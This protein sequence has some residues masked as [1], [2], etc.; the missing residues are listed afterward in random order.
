MRSLTQQ[1][2]AACESARPDSRCT[3]RCN[4]RYHGARREANPYQLLD[5]IVQLPPEDPHF[6]VNKRLQLRLPEAG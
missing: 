3:C 5:Y 4:G 1:L 2:A 6:V